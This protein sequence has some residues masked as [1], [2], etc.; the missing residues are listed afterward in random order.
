MLNRL[1]AQPVTLAGLILFS[2]ALAATEQQL[3]DPAFNRGQYLIKIAGCNDCHTPGYPEN[4]GTTPQDQWLTG[5]AVGF[6]G[7]WGTSYPSNLRLYVQSVTESQ[8]RQ[9]VRHPMLPPMPWFSLRD[10][11][12]DDLNAI[13]RFI[14]VL[15]PRGEPAPKAVAPGLKVTTPYYEFMPKT[16]AS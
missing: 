11:N 9:R 4:G 12:D 13:Y 15:G 6:L 14:H 2:A 10:M 7:P 1:C 16:P 8:W 5:S 3:E